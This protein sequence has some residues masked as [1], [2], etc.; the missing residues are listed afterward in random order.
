[1]SHRTPAAMIALSLLLASCNDHRAPTAAAPYGS[2]P[3][4]STA[5]ITTPARL[6][7]Q[8]HLNAVIN[9]GFESDFAGW[10]RTSTGYGINGVAAN[11]MFT[12]AF[13]PYNPAAYAMKHPEALAH[14]GLKGL[15]TAHNGSTNHTLYQD[16]TLPTTSSGQQV[17]LS[18]WIRW[19]NSV[20]WQANQ[21]DIVV[22]LANPSTGATITELFRASSGGIPLFSGG[23]TAASAPYVPASFDLTPYAGQT[24]RLTFKQYGQLANQ[25]MDL[26]DIA[27]VLTNDEN[28]PPSVDIGGP[29]TGQ[30]GAPVTLTATGLDPDG[31]PLT[32]TWDLDH[33]GTF[34]DATGA[35][36]T[37][38][39]TD[40][41]TFPIHV[42]LTDSEGAT[43]TASTTVTVSNV[44]PSLA[45][46]APTTPS[47]ISVNSTFGLTETMFT[48][49]GTDDTHTALI[50]WGD[51]TT[52]TG[53]AAA[54]NIPA[55]GHVYTT[56]GV[57]PVTVTLTDDDGGSATR[58]YEYVVVYDPSAGFVTGGGVID[59]P[60]GA[61]VADPELS[62]RASFGFVSKYQKGASIPTGNTT[63]QFHSANFTFKSAAYDWLVIAGARAQYKGTGTV[64]GA[65]AYGFLLTATDGQV[66]GGGGTDR[67]RMKV[68]NLATGTVVYDNQMGADNNAAP[69]TAL[70]S[71]SI[72][73]HK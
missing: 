59:S 69:T 16:V 39:F 28:R 25:V 57:Y 71:G 34:D 42:Q 41:G 11:G 32:Y 13:D 3:V 40:N 7:V 1:M 15:G 62:G 52:S 21:Q 36:A 33:D 72:V 68:W 47:L 35:T 67:F 20:N 8:S 64:N 73:I 22:S 23:G 53:T 37:W 49:P 26:D 19:K 38:T 2:P 18:Y 63:F 54:G 29:Y 24:V 44:N 45:P 10:T 65:G 6:Q 70:T 58:T 55:T 50:D 48:D 56:P 51:G 12:A 60:A 43:S 5:T 31:D 30:E 66:V 46:L 17:L 61:Y 4:N 9:G 14:S 27:I